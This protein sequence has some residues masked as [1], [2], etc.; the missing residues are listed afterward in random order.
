MSWALPEFEF[1]FKAQKYNL[2]FILFGLKLLNV[3]NLC[4]GCDCFWRF[5]GNAI[6]TFLTPFSSLFCDDLESN[7][8]KLNSKPTIYGDFHGGYQHPGEQDCKYLEN[9][10]HLLKAE[11]SHIQSKVFCYSIHLWSRKT[12]WLA[13]KKRVTENIVYKEH[14]VQTKHKSLCICC[15]LFYG[16]NIT[17]PRKHYLS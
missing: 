14:N 9:T 13:A 17:L 1:K 11:S 3:Y 4:K 16:T 10:K 15:K 7:D 2:L 8:I 5:L 12:S 6:E